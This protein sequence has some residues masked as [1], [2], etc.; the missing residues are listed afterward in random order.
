ML[1]QTLACPGPVCNTS[2]ITLPKVGFSYVNLY[3]AQGRFVLCHT[4]PCSGSV[5]PVS[6][7]PCSGSVCPVSGRNLLSVGLFCVTL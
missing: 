6:E 4:L 2:H 7:G 1:C 5:G 3:L